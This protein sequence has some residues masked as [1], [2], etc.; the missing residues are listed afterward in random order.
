M[1]G[2]S[3]RWRRL[4]EMRDCM[5]VGPKLQSYL[6]GEL[7]TVSVRRVRAHLEY[8]RKCGLDVA[9]YSEIKRA[10]ATRGQPPAEALARLRA[11]AEQLA[12]AGPEGSADG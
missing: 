9:A 2:M 1:S 11:F 6:D 12:T 7:S 5:H 8:C 3:R 10:L 4:H